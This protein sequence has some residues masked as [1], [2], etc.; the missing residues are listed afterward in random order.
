MVTRC[1]WLAPFPIEVSSAYN[2]T[3]SLMD[4]QAVRVSRQRAAAVRGTLKR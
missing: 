1:V 2:P 3:L 4:A